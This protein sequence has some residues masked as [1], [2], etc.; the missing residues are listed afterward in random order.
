M[1]F[2]L[3]WLKD[4]LETSA[5]LDEIV[6]GLIGVGLEVEEV[7][8]KTKL[9]APFKVAFVQEAIKHPNADKLRL[10]KVE[11][12]Q[13]VI[14]AVCGAPNARTGMKGIVALPGSYIP[15][16]KITLEKGVIRGQESQGMLCSE[17]EL[18]ISQGMTAS[19]RLPATGPSAR[20]RSRRWVSTTR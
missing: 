3:S 17:R 19:S 8:D 4:H 2:T 18:L 9:L 6:Q 20:R 5:S 15:G 16:T 7:D 10:C 12:E 11:T 14:Q 1:K 13:G